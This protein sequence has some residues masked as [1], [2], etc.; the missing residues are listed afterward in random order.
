MGQ[1][2]TNAQ[3]KANLLSGYFASVV[4]Q[5]QGMPLPII[6]RKGPGE[7]DSL[8]SINAD[9]VKEHLER[10]DTFKS[11]GPD[12]LHPTVLEE[13]ANIIAQPLTQIFK[14]SWHSGE[15]PEDWKKANVEN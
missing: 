5:S 6:G 7:G 8:P 4:Y 15:M 2:I 10:L 11:A 12:S 14:N 3:E 9:L 1:L 13:L